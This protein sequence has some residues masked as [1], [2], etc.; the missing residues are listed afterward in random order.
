MDQSPLPRGSSQVRDR[1]GQPHGTVTE[2]AKTTVAVEAEYPAHPSG[3]MIVVQMLRVGTATDRA[4]PALL[5]Q[6]LL[7]LFLA[8]AVSAPQVVLARPTVQAKLALLALR[9]AARFAVSAVTSTAGAIPWKVIEGLGG[10]AVGASPVARWHQ[11][12]LAHVPALP[13]LQ[14]LRVARLRSK[15]EAGLAVAAATV[16][17]SAV[18]AKLIKGQPLAAVSAAAVAIP[19]IQRTRHVRF[20]YLCPTRPLFAHSPSQIPL[21]FLR[22]RSRSRRGGRRRPR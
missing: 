22:G 10:A 2:L 3:A 18:S 16:G 8:H 17:A 21:R 6:E 15:V 9:I 11:R 19:V 1:P 4:D 13:L 5:G 20:V 14:A 12:Q 7:K